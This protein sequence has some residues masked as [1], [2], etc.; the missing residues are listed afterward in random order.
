MDFRF[1][2][3]FNLHQSEQS[4]GFDHQN[5]DQDDIRNNVTQRRRQ[6]STGKRFQKT[7][8]HA[9]DNSSPD[10]VKPPQN[11]YGK[12]FQPDGAQIMNILTVDDAQDDAADAG[13]H[14]SDRPG[15]CKHAPDMNPQGQCRLLIVGHGP[16]ENP[17]G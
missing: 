3:S 8:D 5:K 14:C 17:L 12:H 2:D 16:H 11:D 7:D 10:A 4:V 6:V 9:A 1:L 13:T 15:Q